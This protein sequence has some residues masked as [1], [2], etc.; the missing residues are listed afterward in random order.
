MRL[1]AL[2]FSPYLPTIGHR[3]VE[4][5]LLPTIQAYAKALMPETQSDNPVKRQ[6]AGKCHQALLV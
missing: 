4:Q 2:P 1:S 6:E 3:T 5:L